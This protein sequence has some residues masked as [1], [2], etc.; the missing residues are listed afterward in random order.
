MGKGYV[1]ASH[2]VTRSTVAQQLKHRWKE[3]FPERQIKGL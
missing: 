1:T 3:R 2:E